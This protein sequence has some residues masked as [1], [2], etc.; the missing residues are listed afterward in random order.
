ML[1][2]DRV[3]LTDLK[4]MDLDP[5]LDLDEITFVVITDCGDRIVGQRKSLEH[6]RFQFNLALALRDDALAVAQ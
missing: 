5:G 6:T 2:V 1:E 4:H 3:P